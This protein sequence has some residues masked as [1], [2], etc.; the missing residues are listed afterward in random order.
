MSVFKLTSKRDQTK[1]K[2]FFDEPVTIARYDR[3]KYSWIDKLTEKQHGFFWRPQEID[4]LRDA[5]DFKALNLHEQHIFTSNLNGIT[6]RILIES[7]N[8]SGQNPNRIR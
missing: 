6:D 5:K 1:S 3:Q 7:E 2:A 4:V 8:N